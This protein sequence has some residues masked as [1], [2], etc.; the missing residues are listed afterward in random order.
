MLQANKCN[1]SSK[2][3][4]NVS[5]F[6][7]AEQIT[8]MTNMWFNLWIN[9]LMN[10]PQFKWEKIKSSSKPSCI[11]FSLHFP[12]TLVF[13]LSSHNQIQIMSCEFMNKLG[14]CNNLH[15][16]LPDKRKSVCLNRM[17]LLSFNICIMAVLIFWF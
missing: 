2:P 8:F 10:P 5:F 15:A 11:F 3:W 13:I 17:R 12:G 14:A 7:K 6:S 4:S 1:M 16:F 9:P